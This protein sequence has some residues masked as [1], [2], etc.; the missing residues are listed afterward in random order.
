M[1]TGIIPA[2]AG[3]TPRQ[4]RPRTGRS[5][6]PRSRGVYWMPSPPSLYR[7]G[8]SPL[9][10]GLRVTPPRHSHHVGI[11]PARAGFTTCSSRKAL[12]PT[13]HPRSRGVYRQPTSAVAS[14]DGSSPLARGLPVVTLVVPFQLGIIPARAGF[15]DR[16]RPLVRSCGDHPRSR[17]V[18]GRTSPVTNAPRGS[19]PLARGLPVHPV[20]PV[21][22]VGIIPARAGFTAQRDADRRYAEGSSPLARGLQNCFGFKS[23]G[24]RIIPAR[25]GF[26]GELFHSRSRR[27]GSS[28]LARG[29]RS[30]GRPTQ[31]P[32]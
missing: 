16:S 13:D 1:V 21:P 18:Y 11:I 32:Q 20:R 27:S 23:K 25:A 17:G 29:L 5:D 10:R 6:H 9:A 8:S 19:S 12:T 26:T 22:G 4:S 14:S 28:P 7:T 30:L 15:T 24:R 3:F 2:R 31:Y